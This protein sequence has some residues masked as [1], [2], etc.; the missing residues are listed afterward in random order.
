MTAFVDTNVLAY[1]YDGSDETKRD[2]AL[3]AL[4]AEPDFVVSTQVLGEL[5]VVLTR[6]LGVTEAVAARAVELAAARRVVAIDV[7]LVAAA[8]ALTAAYPI[9][10]WDALIVEAA[11]AAGCDRLITED[12]AD[13]DRVRGVAVVSPFRPRSSV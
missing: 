11:V 10:Y 9:S 7:P 4:R 13:G 6:K 8:I 5:F 2:L 1:L 12:L 3:E